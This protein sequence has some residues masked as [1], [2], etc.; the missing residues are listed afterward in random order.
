VVGHDHAQHGVA[1]ELEALVRRV[2]RVLGAPRTVDEGG[3]DEC[4]VEVDTEAGDEAVEV[5]DRE[6]DQDS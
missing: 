6:V 1:Q 4:S 3:R 5:G 2:P